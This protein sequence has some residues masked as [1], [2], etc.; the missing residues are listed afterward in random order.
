MMSDCGLLGDGL[1][2]MLRRVFQD[3][4]VTRSQF[5]GAKVTATSAFPYSSCF[6]KPSCPC[7]LFPKT[8]LFPINNPSLL[9]YFAFLDIF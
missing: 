1:A 6:E 7:W 3:Y 2:L 9:A 4:D 5:V 8:F